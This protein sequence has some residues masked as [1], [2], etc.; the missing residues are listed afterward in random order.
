MINFMFAMM[1]FTW[2]LVGSFVFVIWNRA[3]LGGLAREWSETGLLL[4]QLKKL[5]GKKRSVMKSGSTGDL[6][7]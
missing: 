6:R 4:C 3:S 5:R 1:R 2:T 7:V